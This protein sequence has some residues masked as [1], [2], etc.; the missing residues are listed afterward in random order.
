MLIIIEMLIKMSIEYQLVS[1]ATL[2]KIKYLNS[3]SLTRLLT[4]LRTGTTCGEGTTAVSIK[5][6]NAHSLHPKMPFFGIHSVYI[7]IHV[8]KDVLCS[9]KQHLKIVK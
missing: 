4:A 3:H 9:L 5:M 1:R 2:V 7:I 6:V 8:S